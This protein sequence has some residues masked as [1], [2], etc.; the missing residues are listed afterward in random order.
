[1]FLDSNWQEKSLSRQITQ[2]YRAILLKSVGITLRVPREKCKHDWRAMECDTCENPNRDC[3]NA[4]PLR[5]DREWTPKL[6]IERNEHR[7]RVRTCDPQRG[8]TPK[9]KELQNIRA[10]V[11]E[12][13]QRR[14]QVEK[15]IAALPTLQERDRAEFAELVRLGLRKCFKIE[16]NGVFYFHEKRWEKVNEPEWRFRDRN[17]FD[18]QFLSTERTADD[19]VFQRYQFQHL[20]RTEGR[21]FRIRRHDDDGSEPPKRIGTA[22]PFFRTSF[23]PH[24]LGWY[25]GDPHNIPPWNPVEELLWV[26]FYQTL[27]GGKPILEVGQ[28][29]PNTQGSPERCPHNVLGSAYCCWC[30]PVF[31]CKK[32]FGKTVA[33]CA[34]IHA[35]ETIQ[36]RKEKIAI[37]QGAPLCLYCKIGHFPGSDERNWWK[38]RIKRLLYQPESE[39]NAVRMELADAVAGRGGIIRPGVPESTAKPTLSRY[40]GQHADPGITTPEVVKALSQIFKNDPRLTDT[41]SEGVTFGDV[42]Q[43]ICRTCEEWVDPRAHK[44]ETDYYQRFRAPQAFDTTLEWVWERSEFERRD[45]NARFSPRKARGY[46]KKMIV[47]LE[48][49]YALLRELFPIITYDISTISGFTIPPETVRQF[50][51]QKLPSGSFIQVELLSEQTKYRVRIAHPKRVEIGQRFQEYCKFDWTAKDIANARGIGERAVQKSLYEYQIL[52]KKGFGGLSE[53]QTS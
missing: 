22:L 46:D 12:S 6:N 10:I 39:T 33:W 32:H 28:L 13:D 14:A 21:P 38:T 9:E 45:E 50:L 20:G 41:I 5:I 51:K 16:P 48:D 34:A 23:N 1:M 47:P 3:T 8:K 7:K 44:F 27:S 37:N 11:R 31:I 52:A 15:R 36:H 30:S 24:R 19:P 43:V 35:T 40:L 4:N 25:P 18:Y 29:A 42:A 2:L 53:G 26:R 49:V 17:D